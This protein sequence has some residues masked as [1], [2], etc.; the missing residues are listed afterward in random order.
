MAYLTILPTYR[1]KNIYTTDPWPLFKLSLGGFVK[2][3]DSDVPKF[4]ANHV[5][6]IVVQ[7]QHN[8]CQA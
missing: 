6:P 8:V 1:R 7:I 4:L 2:D 3:L 5:T